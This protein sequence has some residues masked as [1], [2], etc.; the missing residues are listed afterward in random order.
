MA[1][2]MSYEETMQRGAEEYR[3]VLDALAAVGLEGQFVQTGGMC[4]AIEIMLDGGYYL[5]L[6][7][8]DDTLAWDRTEHAGWQ[9]SLLEPEGRETMDGP[10]EHASDPDGSAASAV[11][12]SQT[13]L[14]RRARAV[15]AV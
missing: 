14:K 11:L 5:L 3:D 6:T 4:A 9:A 8:E 13:A 12:L 10:L 7:D 1:T 15:E 2:Q